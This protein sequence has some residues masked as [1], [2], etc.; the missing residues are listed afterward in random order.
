[1]CAAAAGVARAEAEIADVAA[2]VGARPLKAIGGKL[3]T[4]IRRRAPAA[5]AALVDA[6]ILP[7]SPARAGAVQMRA[8]KVNNE[9]ARPQSVGGLKKKATI[10]RVGRVVYLTALWAKGLTQTK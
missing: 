10:F 9:F 7:A 2:L 6:G 5:L 3:E 1:M 4:Y 8:I